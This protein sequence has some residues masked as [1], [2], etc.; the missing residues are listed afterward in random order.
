MEHIKSVRIIADAPQNTL[1]N[2]L[3]LFGW[4]E[5]DQN[6]KLLETLHSSNTESFLAVV[7]CCNILAY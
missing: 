5:I 7:V 4:Y 3:A 2:P 1:I 6:P